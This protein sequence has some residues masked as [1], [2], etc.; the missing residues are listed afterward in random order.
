MK[1]FLKIVKIVKDKCWHENR[2]FR[3]EL[4]GHVID[5]CVRNNIKTKCTCV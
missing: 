2:E 5:D 4:I 1:M 3:R